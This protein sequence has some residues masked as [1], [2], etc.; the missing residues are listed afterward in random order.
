VRYALGKARLDRAA[1]VPGDAA[2]DAAAVRAQLAAQ[3]HAADAIALQAKGGPVEVT[4][5]WSMAD[6]TPVRAAYRASIGRMGLDVSLLWLEGAERIPIHP[7]EKPTATRKPLAENVQETLRVTPD[8][9]L[10]SFA[11]PS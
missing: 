5:A 11:P 6:G 2:F 9:R 3:G 4:F 10:T 8:G 1:F 7:R